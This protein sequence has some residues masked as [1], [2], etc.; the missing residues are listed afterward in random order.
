[1]S[2][3]PNASAPDRQPHRHIVEGRNLVGWLGSVRGRLQLITVLPT[4]GLVVLT[5][6]QAHASSAVVADASRARTLAATST[7]TMELLHHLEREQAE[8]IALRDRGG[9]VGELLVTAQRARTDKALVEFQ[10]ATTAALSAA[11]GLLDALDNASLELTGLGV[12]RSAAAPAPVEASGRSQLEVR[13]LYVPVTAALLAVADAVPAQILNRE[14]GNQT[15]AMAA[16]GAA[17]HALA[18]QRDVLRTV[19]RRHAFASGESHAFVSLVTVQEER[20]ASFDRVAGVEARASLERIASGSDVE[21]ATRMRDAVLSGASRAL[22]VDSDAWYVAASHA[23]RWLHEVELSLAAGLAH[24]ADRARAD[25]LHGA[26]L[27]VAGALTLSTVAVAVA[28]VIANRTSRRLRR[29]R[30]AALDTSR[31][32]PAVVDEIGWATDPVGVRDSHIAEADRPAGLVAADRQ[33][34]IGHVAVAFAAVHATALRLA[35]DQSLQRLDTEALVVA[36]ARRSQRLV[37]RQLR[38]I[39]ELELN[40]TDPDTLARYYVVDHLAARMRRNDENLL[41][42]AGAESGRR[43]TGLFPLLDVLRAASA[44][45]EDYARVDPSGIP[46]VAVAGHAVGDLVHLLA[47]LLENATTFSPSH[48]RVTV[49]AKRTIDGILLAIYDNGAGL[50]PERLAEVNGRLARPAMLTSSLAGTLGLL[51]VGRLAARQGIGIEVR[52]RDGA[53]TVA[54]VGLPA[55]I[56]AEQGGSE[57]PLITIAWSHGRPV[58]RIPTS[59]HPQ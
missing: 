25:A 2:I 21:A 17:K 14:L 43:F 51:V 20:L 27:T 7:A 35:T 52:S 29:L 39:D 40:E 44:E 36:L 41:V 22:G 3:R 23:L 19:F 18:G 10:A 5:G 28:A 53:G 47:E 56:L 54:L 49:T 13:E 15:R 11:P 55:R 1:L 42:L 4:V 31:R 37:Q 30:D 24:S 57:A 38:A 33:D 46:E 8:T 26:F 34:E 6:I 50:S 9:R 12:V 59:G 32:L 48:T 58:I 16:L 45:I